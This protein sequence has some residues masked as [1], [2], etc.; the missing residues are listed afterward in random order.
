MKWRDIFLQ[1]AV[2]SSQ[3]CKATERILS[4]YIQIEKPPKVEELKEEPTD[5]SV[6]ALYDAVH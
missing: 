4:Y 2:S 3:A 6:S 1:A 5:L